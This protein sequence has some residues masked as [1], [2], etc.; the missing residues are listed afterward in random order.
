MPALAGAAAIRDPGQK[1]ENYLY[2]LYIGSA[3]VMLING[4]ISHSQTVQHYREE[5]ETAA[6]SEAETEKNKSE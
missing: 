2:L 3:V 5:T 4:F 1:R 6:D